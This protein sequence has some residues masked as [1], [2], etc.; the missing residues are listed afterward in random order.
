MTTTGQS[1]TELQPQSA[2]VHLYELAL[3]YEGDSFMF[4]SPWPKPNGEPSPMPCDP[5]DMLCHRPDGKIYRISKAEFASTYVYIS[6]V[7]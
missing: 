5:G 3:V 2:V 1:E 4:A 7:K 6:D